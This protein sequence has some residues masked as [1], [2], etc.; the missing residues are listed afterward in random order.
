MEK[1]YR[2]QEA[3]NGRQ[4]ETNRAKI[5]GMRN[6][7]YSVIDMLITMEHAATAFQD[8]FSTPILSKQLGD[9]LRKSLSEGRQIAQKWTPI[10]NKLGGHIDVSAIEAACADYNFKGVFL[11]PDLETD[12]SGFNAIL[13]AAAFNESGFSEREFGRRVNF[14]EHGFVPEIALMVTKLN[15]DWARVFAC[16]NPLI[17]KMYEIGKAEKEAVTPLSERQGLIVGE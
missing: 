17:A 2:D 14:N 15:Q 10:R 12:V 1:I 16:I 13:I 11:T 8:V 5:K 7:T 9:E 3:L 4:F 6:A